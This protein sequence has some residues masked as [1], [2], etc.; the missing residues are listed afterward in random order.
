MRGAI[1]L[2]CKDVGPFAQ[3]A[4]SAV[5]LSVLTSITGLP[6][7]R[8]DPRAPRP[9]GWLPQHVAARG[10]IR[11]H[12]G[13]GEVVNDG[14]SRSDHSSRMERG[15]RTALRPARDPAATALRGHPR[16]RRRLGG[17]HRR[18]GPGGRLG[19]RP[20]AL[21][22]R[23]RRRDAARLPLRAAARLRRR[24]LLERL[25]VGDADLVIG[26]RFAGDGDYTVRGPR[27]WA[28]SPLSVGLS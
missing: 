19:R 15:G 10:G 26:A 25:A 5:R 1:C 2:S 28:M 12:R 13:T 17:Q 3:T 24:A 7:R 6:V 16:G 4:P 21:Q 11:R 9:A 8:A 27:K 20:A 18:G 14:R 23:C 22:P